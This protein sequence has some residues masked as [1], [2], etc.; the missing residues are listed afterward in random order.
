MRLCVS[1]VAPERV[2]GESLSVCIV[3]MRRSGV[4]VSNTKKKKRLRFHPARLI[5]ATGQRALYSSSAFAFNTP[6]PMAAVASFNPAPVGDPSPS[7]SDALKPV[8]DRHIVATR[9]CAGELLFIFHTLVINASSWAKYHPGGV[10]AILHFVGRDATD[11]VEAYH[12]KEALARIRKYAVGRVEVDD[13]LGWPPLTPPIALGLIRHPNGTKGDWMREGSVRLGRTRLASGQQ[14]VVKLKP[15]D[16]EP[17]PSELDLRMERRRSKAYQQL[18]SKLLAAGMFEWP[19]PLIG[20]GKDLARYGLLG[21][22]AFALFFL[23]VS[24][25]NQSSRESVLISRTNNAIGQLGSAL[26]LGLFWHQLTCESLDLQPAALVM[27]NRCSP[28]TRC[29]AYVRYW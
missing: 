1:W 4:C 25:F 29:R 2:C 17:E 19:G 15:E 7:S 12:S 3:C 14:E 27:L 10:L 16:L 21:G 8:L 6:S 28:R 5:V 11:E 22:S 23:R 13:E 24:T 26:F 20:Y 9:I 18:K